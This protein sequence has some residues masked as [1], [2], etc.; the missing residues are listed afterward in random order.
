[1]N[2]KLLPASLPK[3][4]QLGVLSSYIDYC[5]GLRIKRLHA[6]GMTYDLIDK[7]YT[8]DGSH[9]LSPGPGT[10]HAGYLV[11]R[12]AVLNILK[13]LQCL[14]Q[15]SS[16]SRLIGRKAHL[17]ILIQDHGLGSPRSNI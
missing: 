2:G 10:C 9:L 6:F 16:V 8:Q 14:L 17:G 4:N 3:H 15:G 13:D 1:M 12:K 11:L 7:T 5:P